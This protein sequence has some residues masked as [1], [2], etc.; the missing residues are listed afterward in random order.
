MGAHYPD[1]RKESRKIAFFNQV[2]ISREISWRFE[3]F[4]NQ[5]DFYEEK[6]LVGKAC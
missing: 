1:V 3:S 4:Q 6:V 2:K 5:K